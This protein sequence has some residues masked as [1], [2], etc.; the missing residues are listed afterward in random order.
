MEE[1]IT[2][3]ES[4]VKAIEV[5]SVENVKYL[6]DDKTLIVADVKFSDFKDVLPYAFTKNESDRSEAVFDFINNNNIEI[7]DYEVTDDEMKVQIINAVQE[8]LDNEAKTKGYDNGFACASYA[9]STVETFKNEA[10]AFIAWRDACWVKCY[11][12]LEQYQS[13]LIER[14]TVDDVLNKLPNMEWV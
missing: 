1:F 13:G 10:D 4:K 2:D 6:N 11:S 3:E 14:P 5:E 12:L 8:R 9:S 7:Q